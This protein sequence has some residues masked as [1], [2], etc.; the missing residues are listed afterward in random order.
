[1]MRRSEPHIRHISTFDQGP[2][3]SLR[4]GQG[5]SL[6]GIDHSLLFFCTVSNSTGGC[7]GFPPDFPDHHIFLKHD[8][9]LVILLLAFPYGKSELLFTFSKMKDLI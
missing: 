5:R 8:V 3:C 2:F 7:Q 4:V 6:Q 1:M 9:Q